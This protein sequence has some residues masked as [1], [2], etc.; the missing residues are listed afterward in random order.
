MDTTSQS[1]TLYLT[2]KVLDNCPYKIG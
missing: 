2:V 1:V